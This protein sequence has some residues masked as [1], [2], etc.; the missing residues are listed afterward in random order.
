MRSLWS[1]QVLDSSF[2]LWKKQLTDLQNVICNV[3]RRFE[4]RG[5]L[6]LVRRS[7]DPSFQCLKAFPIKVGESWN[8]GLSSCESGVWRQK[9]PSISKKKQYKLCWEE[10][11]FISPFWHSPFIPYS[12]LVILLQSPKMSKSAFNLDLALFDFSS[13]GSGTKPVC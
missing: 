1:C 2:L 11:G 9:N 12:H 13:L 10:R 8:P 5:S 6:L 7:L 4:G 3:A